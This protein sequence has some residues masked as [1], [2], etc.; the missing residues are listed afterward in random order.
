M[1]LHLLTTAI[2]LTHQ[3]SLISGNSVLQISL[4]SFYKQFYSILLGGKNSTLEFLPI[5][6]ISKPQALWYLWG[7]FFF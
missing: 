6:T 7:S 4:V 3:N 1:V 2:C 5:P